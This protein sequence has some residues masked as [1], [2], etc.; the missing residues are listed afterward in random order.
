MSEFL[1]PGWLKE[2]RRMI[3]MEHGR[4]AYIIHRLSQGMGGTL[5]EP[6]NWQRSAFRL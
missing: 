2:N 1:V 5:R 3:I 6:S 4:V